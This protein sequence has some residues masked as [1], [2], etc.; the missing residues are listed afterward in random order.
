MHS[1]VHRFPCIRMRFAL[2]YHN[3]RASESSLNGSET[4]SVTV[5]HGL[6]RLEAIVLILNFIHLQ[7]LSCP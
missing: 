2:D 1:T 5:E 3:Q 7:P 4:Y 6:L